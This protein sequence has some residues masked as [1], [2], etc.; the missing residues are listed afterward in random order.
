M[1]YQPHKQHTFACLTLW[2]VALC[3]AACAT[4]PP[5]LAATPAPPIAL[6]LATPSPSAPP[7]TTPVPATALPT[8]AT[9]MPDPTLMAGL[10]GLWKGD[11]RSFYLFNS[12]GTWNWDQ[13]SSSV[14]QS[15]E[16]RGAWWIEGDV[17]NIV[18]L[19]GLDACPRNQTGRY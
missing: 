8:G 7:S 2:I 4:T 13:H 17:F 1:P 9:A 19:S 3:V 10:I 5:Q 18:D 15:P 12:D 6:A 16:N 11:N 14:E